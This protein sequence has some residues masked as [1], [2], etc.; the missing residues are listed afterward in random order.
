M[1][2]REC[3]DLLREFASFIEDTYRQY[4]E[5]YG[6][7][8]SAIYCDGS[9]LVSIYPLLAQSDPIPA[10]LRDDFMRFIRIP[11]LNWALRFSFQTNIN[12]D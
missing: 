9:I 2:N 12:C 11:E 8:L 7:G 3:R 5:Q 1:P 10:M 4:V 6:F